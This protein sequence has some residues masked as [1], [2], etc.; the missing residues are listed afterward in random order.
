MLLTFEALGKD[1]LIVSVFGE[2]GEADAPALLERLFT[3][4]DMGFRRTFLDMGRCRLRDWSALD[5][6]VACARRADGREVAVLT[7]TRELR[8]LLEA[9]GL[10]VAVPVYGSRA[11]A[12]Q[13]AVA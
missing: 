9:T 5:V 1:G 12:L 8:R 3:F 2:L 7:P 4:V 6:L 11:E 10:N 13:Q